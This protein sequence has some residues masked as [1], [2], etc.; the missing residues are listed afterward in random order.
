MRQRS[1][2]RLAAEEF[3]FRPAFCAV[4]L[5]IAFTS[6]VLVAIASGQRP[7]ASFLTLDRSK[8]AQT[9][10]TNSNSA[11]SSTS[12]SREVKNV[13]EK[14]AKAVVKIRGTDEHG[15]FACTGFFIDPAG[16]LYTFFVGNDVEGLTAEFDG[17]KYPARTLVADK[18]SRIALL[19]ADVATPALPIGTSDQVEVATPLIA[20]GY[21]LDLPATPSF[22]MV[23]GFDRKFLGRYFP[24]THLRVNLATQRGE[25]G[26]PLLNF[27][28][29]VV[30][31]LVSNLENGSA[32]Y[33]L[34]INAAEKVRNDFVRF[35]EARYG[36]IGIEVGD[37][38]KQKEGSH[39]EMTEI[40][41]DT[42]AFGSGVKPG[43][44]LLQIGKWKIHGPED[45]IDASF[46][47]SAGDKVP[48]TV[49]RGDE[50]M[51]FEIEADM[52]RT[53]VIAGPTT[54]QAIPLRL[55]SIERT[56]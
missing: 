47:I 42:P 17:K 23:A 31:I 55:D 10:S 52:D 21:P 19:Q 9:P 37:A 12:I 49:I 3:S 1:D 56:P 15:D 8:A 30:G 33:A 53:P 38:E 54:N 26:A 51:T 2:S 18:R 11:A 4:R 34:P 36:R 13:F 43:D 24:T 6:L 29:E 25:A 44:I 46:F 22:G 20:I 7:P 14:S 5:S 48:I 50:K 28:G 41:Q 39:A 35:G 27:K 32:C 16:M 40:A 45:V